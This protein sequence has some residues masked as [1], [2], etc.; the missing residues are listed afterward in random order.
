MCNQ[1]KTD[2]YL[3]SPSLGFDKMTMS[4]R[5][6]MFLGTTRTNSFSK[7]SLGIGWKE[8]FSVEYI[9]NSQIGSSSFPLLNA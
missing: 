1:R 6:I 2:I 5:L 3:K 8:Q 9:M 4:G 7:P